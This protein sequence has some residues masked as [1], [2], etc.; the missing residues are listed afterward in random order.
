M[1]R[2]T[3]WVVLGVVGAAVAAAAGLWVT[4]RVEVAADLA[5]ATRGPLQVTLEVDGR[6]RV[7]HPVTVTAPVS[8]RLLSTTRAAGD[9]VTRGEPLFT[10]VAGASAAARNRDVRVSVRAPISGR[11]LHVLERHERL[12]LVRTPLMEVGDPRDL[13]V[14]AVVPVS[15]TTPVRPGTRMLVRAEN[16]ETR[17]PAVVTQVDLSPPRTSSNAAGPAPTLTVHGTLDAPPPNVGDGDRVNA[18]IVL[19]EGDDVLRIPRTALVAMKSGWRV[20]RVRGGRVEPVTVQVGHRGASE[21][22]IVSGL[23]AGDTVVALPSTAIRRGV[24]VRGEVWGAGS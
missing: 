12:V 22:E 9:A 7:R 14:V 18:F 10:I 5:V 11:V 24:W 21:A 6:T 17:R 23:A 16:G 15:D 2:R 13:E 4:R 19:W 8:G 3:G 20:Y 1:T